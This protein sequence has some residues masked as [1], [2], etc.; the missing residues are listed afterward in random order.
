MANF[1][2]IKKVILEV[3]G[4][5]DSGIVREYADKWAEAIVSLDTDIEVKAKEGTP[6]E[7]PTK[8]TRVTKPTETR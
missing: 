3:A 5:P 6:F 4:N 2:D 1:A 8:E 7:R